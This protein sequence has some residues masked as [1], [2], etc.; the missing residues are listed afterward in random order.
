VLQVLIV[1]KVLKVLVLPCGTG[2]HG[3]SAPAPQHGLHV[4]HV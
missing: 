3:T 2:T 4:Q 1:Q